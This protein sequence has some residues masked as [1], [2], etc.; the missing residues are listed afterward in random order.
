VDSLA[1]VTVAAPAATR[2]HG[3]RKMPIPIAVS[4][5]SRSS[6]AIQPGGFRGAPRRCH[7]RHATQ[8]SHAPMAALTA[9]AA[10]DGALLGAG[11]WPPVSSSTAAMTTTREASQPKM[12]PSPFRTPRLAP[13][14]RMKATSVIGSRVIASPMIRRLSTTR[15]PYRGLAPR[16]GNWPPSAASRSGLPGRPRTVVMIST[17]MNAPIIGPAR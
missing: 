15:V 12:N 9:R 17:A 4:N 1:A 3:C 5:D 11:G 10:V 8:I 2:P 16:C 6:R 13:R 7:R 14:I